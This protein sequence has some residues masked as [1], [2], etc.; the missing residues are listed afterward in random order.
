MSI[1]DKRASSDAELRLNLTRKKDRSIYLFQTVDSTNRLAKEMLKDEPEG[2]LILSES[3]TAGRG[4]MGRSFFS[5]EADGLYMS[6]E[7]K[8]NLP[9]EEAVFLTVMAAVAVT[10]AIEKRYHLKTQIKWVNDIYFENK[11]LCGILVEG[12]ID[13]SGR[14][15]RAIL[16]VGVNLRAPSGGYPDDIKD[17][18]G[19]LSQFSAEKVEKQT[20]AAEIVNCFEELYEG[21]N[22]EGFVN[23]YREKSC[24]IGK[25]VEVISYVGAEPKRAKVLDIDDMARLVVMTPEGKKETLSSGDVSVIIK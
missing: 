20:L 13:G 18:A 24:L 9:A 14:L 11:K 16:G 21:D 8:P 23:E 3:Q 7:L 5:P 12:E 10:R 22:K 19:A 15:S 25:G 4:R 1:E 2:A 6:M 17:K